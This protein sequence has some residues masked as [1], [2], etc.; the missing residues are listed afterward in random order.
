MVPTFVVALPDKSPWLSGLYCTASTSLSWAI[1]KVVILA[2]ELP[3]FQAFLSFLLL[4]YE[5]FFG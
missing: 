4:G 5:Y 2:K 3:D 1:E